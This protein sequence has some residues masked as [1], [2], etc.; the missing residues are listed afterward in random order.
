MTMNIFGQTSAFACG[1]D[2]V[3]LWSGGMQSLRRQMQGFFV[4]NGQLLATTPP[5]LSLTGL[6]QP[7]GANLVGSSQ[8]VT[9]DYAS[10]NQVAVVQ[11]TTGQELVDDIHQRSGLTLEEIAELVGTSRRTIHNWRNGERVNS[12]NERILRDLAD[13][14]RKID[15]G[16]PKATRQ[17]LLQRED[18][19]ISPYALLE[20]QR[21]DAAAAIANGR[22]PVRAEPRS[23]E[24]LRTDLAGRLSIM[25]DGEPLFAGSRSTRRLHRKS[26][27]G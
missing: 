11:R 12:R 13:V 15:A 27:K 18:G 9:G 3:G 17:R 4:Q 23:G 21:Y 26:S 25:P 24:G 14:I 16:D 20:E 1:A 8:V 10:C 19:R 7:L 6:A 5:A 2:D 22:E